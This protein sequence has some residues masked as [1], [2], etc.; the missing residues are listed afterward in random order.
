MVRL[1][2]EERLSYRL[3]TMNRA[4]VFLSNQSTIE[5]LNLYL[6]KTEKFGKWWEK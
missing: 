6:Q 5:N 1:Y 4:A 3:S 2:S